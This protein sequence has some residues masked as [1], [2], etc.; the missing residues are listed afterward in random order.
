MNMCVILQAE[1]VADHLQHKLFEVA[2]NVALDHLSQRLLVLGVE[3]LFDK[4]QINLE[5]QRRHRY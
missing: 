4:Q 3:G 2:G 5:N 1:S